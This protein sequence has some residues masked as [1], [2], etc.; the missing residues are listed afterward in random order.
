ML[1]FKYV[2]ICEGMFFKGFYFLVMGLGWCQILFL[3]SRFYSICASF[4]NSLYFGVVYSMF[5]ITSVSLLFG[6]VISF[7]PFVNGLTI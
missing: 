5:I 1:G 6:L 2:F 4:L 3:S 7:L